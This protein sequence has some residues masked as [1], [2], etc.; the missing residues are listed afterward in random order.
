M[1]WG[2]R[3]IDVERERMGE[4]EKRTKLTNERI[5]ERTNKQAQ[6]TLF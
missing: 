2:A 3:G 6:I 5:N 4:W 1:Y